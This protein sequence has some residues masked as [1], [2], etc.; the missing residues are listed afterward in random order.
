MISLLFTRAGGAVAILR[1]SIGA[2]GLIEWWESVD[3]TG[4]RVQLDTVDKW[5][6][7]SAI[8]AEAVRT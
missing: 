8:H 3:L 1:A 5:L 6:A 2:D 7:I 4:A